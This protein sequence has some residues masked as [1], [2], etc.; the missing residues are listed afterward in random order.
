MWRSARR[1]RPSSLPGLQ[2]RDV[3]GLFLQT[4]LYL[5]IMPKRQLNKRQ[6]HRVKWRLQV[7]HL[8]AV[9]RLGPCS[10][11]ALYEVDPLAWNSLWRPDEGHCL[12]RTQG[13]LIEKILRT[14]RPLAV[15]GTAGTTRCG[16]FDPRPGLLLFGPPDGRPD[17]GTDVR[18][19]RHVPGHLLMITDACRHGGGA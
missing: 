17:A 2:A 6:S 15:L 5:P 3:C 1:L 10:S 18:G 19:H 13:E 9:A 7:H 14:L 11:S 8:P 12:H 4:T 16:W